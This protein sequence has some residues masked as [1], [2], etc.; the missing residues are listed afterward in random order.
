MKL[1]EFSLSLLVAGCCVFPQASTQHSRRMSA[2]S[3][4]T[5]VPDH[6]LCVC[7]FRW[8]PSLTFSVLSC[9]FCN[10]SVLLFFQL[11]RIVG[12]CC[13]IQCSWSSAVAVQDVWNIVEAFSETE[14]SYVTEI[15]AT[16]E[17]YMWLLNFIFHYLFCF[18]ICSL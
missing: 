9:L 8:W 17:R 10:D 18:F 3:Q 16:F 15:M 1:V 13:S 2:C 7:Y 4:W 11:C 5:A 6:C 14:S 12:L